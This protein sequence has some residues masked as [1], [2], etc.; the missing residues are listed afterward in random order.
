MMHMVIMV[1]ALVPALVLRPVL[2]MP[3]VAV[4]ISVASVV[5]MTLF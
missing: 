1:A 3:A 5:A 4:M 2:P